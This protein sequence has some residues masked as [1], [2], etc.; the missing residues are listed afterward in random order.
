[1]STTQ[2]TPKSEILERTGVTL[3]VDNSFANVLKGIG[4]SEEESDAFRAKVAKIGDGPLRSEEGGEGATA[5]SIIN[6]DLTDKEATFLVIYGCKRLVED[7]DK[8]KHQAK[9]NRL[10]KNLLG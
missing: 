8:A 9:I 6:A 2:S 5:A 10:I 3:R 1:M 7:A 4:M